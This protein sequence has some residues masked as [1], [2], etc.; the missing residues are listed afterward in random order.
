MYGILQLAIMSY[1]EWINEWIPLFKYQTKTGVEE[2]RNGDARN[3]IK[4]S[5]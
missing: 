2:P 5:L 3:K 1:D 4:Q